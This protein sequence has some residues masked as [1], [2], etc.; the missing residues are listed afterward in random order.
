MVRQLIDVLD[1]PP[2]QASETAHLYRL[3]AR[4]IEPN[5][6]TCSVAM[7]CASSEAEARLYAYESDPFLNDWL[8]TRDFACEES[9]VL[10]VMMLG[11]VVFT[12]EPLKTRLRRQA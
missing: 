9:H 3:T 1:A 8:N 12:S 5:Q 6:T 11:E 10:R 7:V 4:Y 2:L